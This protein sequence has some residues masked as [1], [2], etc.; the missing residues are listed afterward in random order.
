M[1][2]KCIEMME[3]IESTEKGY[4]LF[5]GTY[6]FAIDSHGKTVMTMDI[7]KAHIFDD[8]FL[9]KR[10]QIKRSNQLSGF[11]R[12]LYFPKDGKIF[13]IRHSKK[14]VFPLEKKKKY[15]KKE[16]VS[17]TFVERI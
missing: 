6:Y 17:V 11:A 4:D 13:K 7:N 12:Y 14:R 5:N 3:T 15:L 2:R 16:T 1:E 10:E 8:A 9:A